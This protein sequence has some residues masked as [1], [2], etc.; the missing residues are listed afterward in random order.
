MDVFVDGM[1]FDPLRALNENG[2]NPEIIKLVDIDF[3]TN[4]Y[5]DYVI[6]LCDK[7]FSINKRSNS[8]II[9]SM[10]NFSG[11]LGDLLYQCDTL[12]L[13]RHYEVDTPDGIC[14]DLLQSW[15][16][17]EEISLENDDRKRTGIARLNAQ[18]IRLHQT[19]D[20]E[21]LGL[22]LE[23]ERARDDYY[24]DVFGPLFIFNLRQLLGA[25]TKF[26]EIE[27]SALDAHEREEGE[28]GPNKDKVTENFLLSLWEIYKSSS[29][30]NEMDESF[31]RTVEILAEAADTEVAKH[32]GAR[33]SR[34]SRMNKEAIRQ[35]LTRSGR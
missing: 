1:A 12:A 10:H 21:L 25:F 33:K 7:L 34:L 18:L 31:Y 9:H 23:I 15:Y 24:G 11:K 27:I 4:A 14:H 22:G 16:R 17:S 8:N 13:A 30:S 29:S 5:R 20:P 3:I 19:I 35:A 6:G 32:Y 26:L 28:S 2:Y